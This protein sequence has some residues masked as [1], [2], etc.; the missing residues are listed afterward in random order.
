[1]GAL[2]A[3]ESA[4]EAMSTLSSLD[5]YTAAIQRALGDTTGALDSIVEAILFNVLAIQATPDVSTARLHHDLSH[6]VGILDQ[7]PSG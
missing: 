5:S 4:V 7:T 2:S 6:A 3:A 1:M